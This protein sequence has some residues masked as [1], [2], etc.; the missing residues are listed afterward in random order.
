VIIMD[1]NG[2]WATRRCLPRTAGHKVGADV[3]KEMVKACI[4]QQIPVLTLFAL[5]IENWSRP[6]EEVS[7]LLSLFLSL[8]EK[9]AGKLHEQNVR[10]RV[11]GDKSRFDERLKKAI[12]YAE[13]LTQ[14]NTGLTLVIAASYSG[15][16]DI[17]QATQRIAQDVAEQKLSPGDVNESI[18]SAYLTLADLPEPD[19]FIR[20]GGEKRVSNFF[21][22]QLAYTEL[23]FTDVFWPDF[24]RAL[25]EQALDAYASR[26]RRFGLTMEQTLRA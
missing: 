14:H 10:I 18:F 6:I 26:Q 23:Y 9:E 1:G 24:S 3:A 25:F 16:W 11:V 17:V 20:T 13:D 19:L 8:L 21:L 2:R 5:G 4:E 12:V 22:W 15:R 7:F